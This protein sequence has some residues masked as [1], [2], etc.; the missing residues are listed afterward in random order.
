M[1][2]HD[3]YFIFLEKFAGPKLKFFWTHEG[4]E[5]YCGDA[6]APLNLPD[7]NFYGERGKRLTKAILETMGSRKVQTM[8]HGDGH[9]GNVF[10]QAE[11]AKFTWIGEGLRLWRLRRVA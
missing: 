11:A 5:Y 10:F 9:P 3:A 1:A 2:N 8:I 6:K 4:T 7:P